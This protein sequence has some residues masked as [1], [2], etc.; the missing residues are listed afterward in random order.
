M[1]GSLRVHLYQLLLAI[2]LLG[3]WEAG[4]RAGVLDGFFFPKPSDIG[5]RIAQWA[6]TE[7]FYT[8]VAI[9]LIE[10][11]LAF[12]LGTLGGVV[13]G[14]WLGLSPLASRV[15]DPFL[16]VMNS[17]PKVI[18]APIFM[19]WFG[20]GLLSKVV[21][22]LTLVFFVAFF[23]TYQ[24]VLEVN[25][26]VLSNAR[27]LGAS[28]ASLLRH[29]YLPS[30]STWILSSLRVSVG[31]AMIGAVVGEYLG[32]AA[33]MGHMIAV[34]EGMFDAVG[35]FAGVAVLSFFVLLVDAAVSRIERP[36]LVWRPDRETT[37]RG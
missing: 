2:V 12:V 19:L 21:L 31:F 4:V 29:V 32:S 16:K 8:Q 36:L 5:A 9:T 7:D 6:A 13:V 34:A 3:G 1:R 26:V 28:R 20:L 33:G 14:L 35:V 15:L 10:A 24:G 17:I 37:T 27:L 22:G 30:A 23:N 11:A 25:P 18:L